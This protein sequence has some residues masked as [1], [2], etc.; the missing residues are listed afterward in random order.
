[1]NYSR[2][3]GAILIYIIISIIDQYAFKNTAE[4]SR[5]A[6]TFFGLLWAICEEEK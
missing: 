4:L 2:Y 1:M 3:I 5:I 6:G